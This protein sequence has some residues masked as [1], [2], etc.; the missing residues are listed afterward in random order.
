MPL[1]QLVFTNFYLGIAQ[2]ALGTASS[3]TRQRTRAWHYATDQKASAS[4][5]F[6]VLETHG[7][8]Q[9]KLWAA[10][11]PAERAASLIEAINAHAETVTAA[12]RGEAA[13]VVAAAEQ[14]AIDVGLE[15]GTRVFEVTGARTTANSV[16]PD[17]AWR[18]IRTHSLHDPV[19]HKRAEVGRWTLL[20]EVPE[21]TWYT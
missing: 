3:Y 6:H 12:E 1:I 4:E 5:E 9:S 21:P 19:A 17:L 7:D 2:G 10:Q 13:V 15:I 18:N 14:R 8:L 16:G 20:G 11:A